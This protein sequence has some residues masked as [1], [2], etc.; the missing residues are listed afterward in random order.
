MGVW[1]PL[2]ISL[3]ADGIRTYILVLQVQKVVVE[4]TSL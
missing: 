1:L 4:I 2:G 3:N